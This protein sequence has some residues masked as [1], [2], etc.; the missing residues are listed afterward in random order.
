M[1]LSRLVGSRVW[2]FG[3]FGA[4]CDPSLQQPLEEDSLTLSP[5]G[6]RLRVELLKTH[7]AAPSLRTMPSEDSSKA[8]RQPK[9]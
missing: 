4:G 9:L 1:P 8:W 7:N 2:E 5:R 3:E 6:L